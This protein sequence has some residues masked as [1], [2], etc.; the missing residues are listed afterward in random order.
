MS[1]PFE[2][3]NCIYHALINDEGQ[4]SPGRYSWESQQVGRSYSDRIAAR[5]VSNLS[6]RTGPT[7]DPIA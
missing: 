7:C 6:K 4:H 2:D 5:P 1:N 3:E